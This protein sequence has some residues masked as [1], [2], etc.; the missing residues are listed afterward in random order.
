MKYEL[1][2]DILELMGN[3]RNSEVMINLIISKNKCTA[4]IL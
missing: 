1:T 3:R 4:A 2:L